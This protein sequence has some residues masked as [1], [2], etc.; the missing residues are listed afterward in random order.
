MKTRVFDKL[1]GDLDRKDMSRL[2]L[3]RFAEQYRRPV[4]TL[5]VHVR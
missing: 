2:K 3:D 5:T 4:A 1:L